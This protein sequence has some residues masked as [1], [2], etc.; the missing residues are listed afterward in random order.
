LRASKESDDTHAAYRVAAFQTFLNGRISTFGDMKENSDQDADLVRISG[1]NRS[2]FPEPTALALRNRIDR[3]R[4]RR[5]DAL[6]RAAS[7]QGGSASGSGTGEPPAITVARVQT[8]SWRLVDF[9]AA[10]A[11]ARKDAT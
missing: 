10:D 4:G 6:R 2:E 11:I 1:K 7:V 5:G 8:R 3:V 9:C